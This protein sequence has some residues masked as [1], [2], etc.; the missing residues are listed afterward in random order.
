M[1]RK[2][3]Y[4]DFT[5]TEVFIIKTLYKACKSNNG[6]ININTKS[7]MDDVN[8]NLGKSYM[9]DTAQMVFPQEQRDQDSREKQDEKKSRHLSQSVSNLNDTNSAVNENLGK[10]YMGNVNENL[11]KSYMG[12]VNENIKFYESQKNQDFIITNY[13]KM[14]DVQIIQFITFIS[15]YI[16]K[17]KIDG[18]EISTI[19]NIIRYR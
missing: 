9:D 1:P 13:N 3:T 16:Y 8:K 2:R 18:I 5:D 4:Y 19:R 17:I 14:T 7:Y 12:N 11:G 10:S 15:K 6:N